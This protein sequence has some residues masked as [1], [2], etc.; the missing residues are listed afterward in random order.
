VSFQVIGHQTEKYRVSTSVYEGPLDLLL[1]L[2]EKAELDITTLAIAQV[3]DQ[4]LA[5]LQHLEYH[6]PEEVSAFLVIASRLILIK[7]SALL[8][9]PTSTDQ[10]SDEIDPAEALAQQ[11]I[12]YKRFKELA[13]WL[14]QRELE[15]YRTYLRV[16]PISVKVNAIP[17]LTGLD[18][19][20]LLSAARSA[21]ADEQNL[22]ALDRVVNLPRVTI[23][24]KIQTILDALR[25]S[26]HTTFKSILTSENR[27]EIVVTFLAM[28]ELIKRRVIRAE[29]NGL[30]DEITI[31]VLGELND[32]PEMELDFNE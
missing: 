10:P 28:L 1:E 29:Q 19:K 6:D 9:R 22:P 24:Q 3:T 20:D 13:Q 18:L 14:N 11:L 5:Y 23:R 16:S 12:L 31:D 30:F 17:D 4:Y 27:V 2:I 25:N 15:G 21:F 7:S 8:P 32:N 26:Q